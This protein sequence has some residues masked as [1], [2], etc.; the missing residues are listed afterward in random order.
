MSTELKG[1][2]K[3]GFELKEKDLRRIVD[4]ITDKYS[5]SKSNNLIHQYKFKDIK[6]LVTETNNIDDI[7]FDDNV[8]SKKISQI[9]LEIYDKEKT[10]Y[11]NV[12]FFDLKSEKD[13][14]NSINYKLSGD[15]RDYVFV[16]ASELDDRINQFKKINMSN[17]VSDRFVPMLFVMAL[18][19]VL[20]ILTF[21]KSADFKKAKIEFIEKISLE[22]YTDTIS[23]IKQLMFDIQLHQPTRS[24]D[25]PEIIYI[26]FGSIMLFFVSY[27]ILGYFL[28]K[29]FFPYNF[30]WGDYASEFE[31]RKK[32]RNGIFYTTIGGVLIGMIGSYIAGYLPALF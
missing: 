14:K 29:F 7:F 6:G 13:E 16:L 27:F 31:K 1:S 20:I 28:D 26:S 11:S 5:N 12:N 24:S 30:V 25:S 3:F 8:G 21:I 9:S 10:H 18:I 15:N 23:G 17:L 32:I 19:P 4:T 22:N 2:F